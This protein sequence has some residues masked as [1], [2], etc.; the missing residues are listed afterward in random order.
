L[1]E[2]RQAALLSLAEPSRHDQ[3]R[4]GNRRDL[5]A[6]GLAFGDFLTLL[7]CSSLVRNIGWA[8]GPLFG[9]IRKT[10]NSRPALSLNVS[11]L[12]QGAFLREY[13]GD[14]LGDGSDRQVLAVLAP[15][16]KPDLARR[17]DRLE[18]A[19]AQAFLRPT[20]IVG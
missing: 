10:R 4:I 9:T 2:I 3:I 6:P 5:A 17:R 20:D 8:R 19:R 7:R 11:G 16:K 14:V 13:P 12:E 18:P 15:C 1:I